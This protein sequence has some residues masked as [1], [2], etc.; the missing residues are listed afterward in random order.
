MP[1]WG[2]QRFSLQSSPALSLLLTSCPPWPPLCSLSRLPCLGAGGS[3]SRGVGPLP[4]GPGRAPTRG[5]SS[6]GR[7]PSDSSSQLTLEPE[8]RRD[9][10]DGRKGGRGFMSVL[11]PPLPSSSSSP[12]PAASRR[13]EGCGPPRLLLCWGGG[14]CV[15]AWPPRRDP[16]P[17]S[18]GAGPLAGGPPSRAH[19][20]AFSPPP[21]AVGPGGCVHLPR[22]QGGSQRPGAGP[23]AH[24]PLLPLS[25]FLGTPPARSLPAPPRARL[26]LQGPPPP[27]GSPLLLPPLRGG[28]RPE[29]SSGRGGRAGRCSSAALF[30]PVGLPGRPASRAS[31]R[32][33]RGIVEECCFRS[34]DLAL[35]ETYCAAP[36]KSER[37]VSTL[38]TV[39]PVRGDPASG[40]RVSPQRRGTRAR[41]AAGGHPPEGER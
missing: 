18:M 25:S 5:T 29:A 3:G 14:T 26:L 20:G 32:S 7:L 21:W 40:C 31:R 22:E 6:P 36:A 17:P 38:P 15:P 39:L 13:L 37:D 4:G 2:S 35:L 28:R 34:C 30:P 9:G 11:T 27:A 10:E 23:G 12:K 41:S 19:T 24:A 33:S 16:V 8:Q 1:A